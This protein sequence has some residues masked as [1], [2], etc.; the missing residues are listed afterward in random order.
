MTPIATNQPEH[1]HAPTHAGAAK[2]GG[3]VDTPDPTQWTTDDGALIERQDI[4]ASIAANVD[5]GMPGTRDRPERRRF[6]PEQLTAVRQ[7]PGLS[8]AERDQLAD[9]FRMTGTE[10]DEPLHAELAQVVAG[11]VNARTS[12]VLEEAAQAIADQHEAYLHSP[13][14]SP[15]WIAG[16]HS[17]NH[18]DVYTLSAL[19]SWRQPPADAPK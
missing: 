12:T 15:D 4:T 2:K 6:T 1:P 16:W 13:G 19:H 7:P 17:A 10:V 8:G 11:I 3:G 14:L 9:W 18:H 5:A